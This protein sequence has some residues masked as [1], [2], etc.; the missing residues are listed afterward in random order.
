MQRSPA[1]LSSPAVAQVTQESLYSA[2]FTGW[3]NSSNRDRGRPPRYA[4]AYYSMG[5]GPR[6]EGAGTESL[7]HTIQ[8]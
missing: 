2:G 6:W 3:W 7:Y 1:M 4:I 5:L 8:V